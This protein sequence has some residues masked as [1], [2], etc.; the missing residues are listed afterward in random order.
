MLVANKKQNESL[1]YLKEKLADAEKLNTELE[2]SNGSMKLEV[3]SYSEEKDNLQN[4]LYGY[5]SRFSDLQLHN[6]NQELEHKNSIS[7]L[8]E[9]INSLRYS[10]EEKDKIVCTYE[11]KRSAIE[12]HLV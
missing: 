8:E 12:C 4:E 10:I 3:T 11:C 5:M 7:T 2:E 1:N 6:E 9:K